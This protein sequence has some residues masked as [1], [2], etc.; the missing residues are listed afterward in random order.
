MEFV[1]GAAGREADLIAV[2]EASFAASE[3]AEEGRVIAELV[4]ELLT[5]TP[6]DDLHVFAT[7]DRGE[8]VAGILF[9]RIR[10]DGDPRTVFLLSPVAVAPDRQ[11]QGLGQ[12][13]I[14]FGIA[15]LRKAGADAAL[16]YGD[17]DYYSQVGFRQITAAEASPPFPLSQPHGWLG[18]ALQNE[19][20]IP[21]KGIAKCVPAF[22]DPAHW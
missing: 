1:T 22:D 15:T 20:F 7:E 2:F 18:Q 8:L 5:T 3:G 9:T 10:F 12:A 21:L 6:P 17:P 14:N 4:G 19:D 16:T 11:R 13:V